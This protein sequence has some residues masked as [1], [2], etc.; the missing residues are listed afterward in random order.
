MTVALSRSPQPL[1]FARSG[2]EALRAIAA[3]RAPQ[4]SICDTLG[5]R[6]VEVGEGWANFL[7][8]PSAAILNPAGFVHGGW[9]LSLIDSAA[10]C[11]A[12]TVLPA[13]AGYTTLETKGNFV[14]AITPRTGLVRAEGRV[15][16]AGRT[17]ITAETRVLDDQSR[18]LAHGLSTVLVLAQREREG[19]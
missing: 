9:A 14:R 4:P 5:F 13:G 8:Q 6:L 17:I 11:A 10:G 19:Q 3:G 2:L 1:I 16:S 18:L 7:G 15:L 12:H